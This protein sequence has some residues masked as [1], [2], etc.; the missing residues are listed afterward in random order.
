MVVRLIGVSA[1]SNFGWW[2][3]QLGNQAKNRSGRNSQ[4]SRS[5][6]GLAPAKGRRIWVVGGNMVPLV[7]LRPR[8]EETRVT[9]DMMAEVGGGIGGCVW[10]WCGYRWLWCLV[11][12]GEAL[13]E[14]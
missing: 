7:E 2:T 8:K 10:V 14:G 1:D 6:L 9:G 3:W 13:V 4:V 12:L 5:F 11:E